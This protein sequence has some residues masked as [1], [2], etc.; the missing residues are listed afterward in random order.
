M[1]KAMIDLEDLGNLAREAGKAIL[2]I[3]ETDFEVEQKADASPL[4]L[5]DRRSHQIISTDLQS[6][7]PAIPVLSEEGKEVPYAIR[8][9]WPAFWLVDPLDGTKEFVKKND[10][11]TVNIALIEGTTPTLGVIYLPV[12]DRLYLADIRQGCW[13][14]QPGTSR[15]LVMGN[16]PPASPARV[17]KSRSHPSPDLEAL[18]ETLPSYESVSRGSSLKFCALAAGEADFYPRLGPT[19]EWDTAAGQAIVTAAGG[20]MVTLDGT[21]FTYNKPNLL[22][23]PFLAAP[24]LAWL[25]ESRILEKGLKNVRK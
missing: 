17:V 18:L 8:R 9:A 11:F 5:A 25:K 21:P 20:V 14:Q 2:E 4:T 16:T 19:W 22:N 6:R 12:L 24:S 1:T 10:E 13:E 7:Y 3:Y 23:G 15:K